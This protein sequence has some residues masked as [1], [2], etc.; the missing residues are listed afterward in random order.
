MLKNAKTNAKN[1]LSHEQ[2][3]YICKSQLENVVGHA[4][5]FSLAFTFFTFFYS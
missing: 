4:D 3:K 2:V 5:I 1:N